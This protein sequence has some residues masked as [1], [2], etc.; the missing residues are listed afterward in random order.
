MGVEQRKEGGFLLV[1]AIVAS[2]LMLFA[3][4]VVSSLFEASIRWESESGNVRRA[5]MVAEK[6]MEQLRALSSQVPAGSSFSE[7]LAGLVG[8]QDPDPDAP[9]FEIDVQILAN[10][11]RPVPSSGLTPID[12]V[13][14]PCSTLFTEAPDPDNLTLPQRN[15][16]DN[17]PQLNN[18]YNTYPYTRHLPDSLQLV[19]VTVTF[20]G[21]ERYRLVSLLGDPVAPFD[22]TPDVVVT[23]VSGPTNLNDFTTTSVYT[24]QVVTATNT[25]PDD[26]TVLWGITNDSTG[27]LVLMPLDSSGRQV[28][29]SRR[30]ITSL[31][32]N[33][34]ARLQ[35]LVRYGGQEAVGFSTTI[36]LP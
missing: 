34:Q 26:I 4:A 6:K 10:T 20:G 9:D 24:A 2:F 8:P 35:A 36:N 28:R 27:S 1:E 21:D 17:N 29:V 22:N 33:A 16:P 5:S 3:F 31:G 14:S 23:R 12:G 15:P 13:H 7:V 25:R 19:Q 18:T 32:M 30:P 11:H